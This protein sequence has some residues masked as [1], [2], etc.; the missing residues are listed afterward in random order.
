MLSVV[1]LNV[2]MVSVKAPGRGA[3]VEYRYFD[4]HSAVYQGAR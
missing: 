1:I 4:C 3:Y 2:V